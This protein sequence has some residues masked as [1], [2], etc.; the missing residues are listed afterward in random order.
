[1]Q[2]LITILLGGRSAKPHQNMS[3]E[4]DFNGDLFC[5]EH[6]MMEDEEPA[7]DIKSR[8]KLGVKIKEITANDLK[9]CHF[10]YR[11]GISLKPF[12]R[13]S[14]S[15]NDEP[16]NLMILPPMEDSMED[17]LISLKATQHEMAMPTITNEERQAFWNAMIR[18]LPAFPSLT[19]T[20]QN[21]KK[22]PLT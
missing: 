20:R 4:T 19:L 12:W 13:L 22:I 21:I 11:S 17:K 5:A 18:T 15:L 10:K 9:R 8:R 3:G 6:L 1:L 2:N 14:I 7:T 16:E